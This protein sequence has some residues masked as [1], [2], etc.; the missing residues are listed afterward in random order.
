VLFV[1]KHRA[2]QSRTCD[3]LIL[4]P[5][6]FAGNEPWVK[7]AMVLILD[8]NSFLYVGLCFGRFRIGTPFFVFAGTNDKI[9]SLIRSLLVKLLTSDLVDITLL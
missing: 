3:S 5:K 2:H 8:L 6:I 7:A 9:I 4:I 1:S